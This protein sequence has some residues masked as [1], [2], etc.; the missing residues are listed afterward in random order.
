MAYPSFFTPGGP[1][2]QPATPV[3]PPT[4][5]PEN[6]LPTPP[7][8]SPY[9]APRPG[10]EQFGVG[11]V[12]GLELPV[13]RMPGTGFTPPQGPMPGPTGSTGGDIYAFIK[14]YQATHPPGN[15]QDLVQALNAAGFNVQRWD[16]G[17]GVLSNN[18]LNI[19]G[20]KFKVGVDDGQGGL[21]SWYEP[22]TD[23]GGGGG[24]GGL[25]GGAFLQPSSLFTPP[26]LEEYMNSPG[27]QTG[28]NRILD[29]GQSAASARGNLFSGG[30]LQDLNEQGQQFAQGGYLDYLNA[31]LGVH[32]ANYNIERNNR[33]DPFNMLSSTAGLGLNAVQGLTNSSMNG[34]NTNTEIDLQKGNVGAA[35]TIGGANATSGNAANIANNAGFLGGSLLDWW[36]QRH[37]G[38]M[39]DPT[40]NSTGGLGLGS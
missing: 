19:N 39:A 6:L 28:L 12:P 9:P 16:V 5:P 21:R 38:N 10:F 18:E 4:T 34:A 40:G 20:E 17:N 3:V 32:G 15:I 29:L 13:T 25:N 22:G 36:K 2:P 8:P 35:G 7:Q 14:Q 1:R 33:L 31:M 30:L 26:S 11:K 37:Q 27:V 24:G 23:D